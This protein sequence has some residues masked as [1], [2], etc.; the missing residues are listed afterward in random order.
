MRLLQ[1][2]RGRDIGVSAILGL[3]NPFAYYLVLF[4]AYDLLPAQEAQPLNYTWPIVLA[5]LAAIVFRQP[6]RVYDIAAMCVCFLGVLFISTR[7]EVTALRFTNVT[8][9][10]LAI[11]SSLI[12]ATYWIATMK[13][14]IDPILRLCMNFFFGSL[15]IG[16]LA[17]IL[18]VWTPVSIAGMAGAVWVGSFEM[19]LTFVLWLSA[20][21]HA[22][23]TS[24]ITN[25][26][27]LSPFLSLIV[28]A[29]VVG[30]TI[31]PSTLIGLVLIV[32][33][34]LLQQRS[35]KGRGAAEKA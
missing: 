6:L 24:K 17:S 19:G 21:R 8:G 16:L 14:R 12:W 33:G 7:G 23:S 3:L 25:L 31:Y 27:F 9:V 13:S 18:G 2:I 32:G 10:A 34:I 28:I 11:G 22:K 4:H 35:S 30:E 15:Y 20:L 1:T 29:L 26:V 5:L